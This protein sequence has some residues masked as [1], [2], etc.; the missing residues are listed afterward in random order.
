MA[1]FIVVYYQNINYLIG[2]YLNGG[3]MNCVNGCKYLADTLD[4]LEPE[5][6]P[7]ISAII[8]EYGYGEL[9]LL[10]FPG[11]TQELRL[12]CES[13]VAVR[14]HGQWI[15]RKDLKITIR[16]FLPVETNK[17]IKKRNTTIDQL[18]YCGVKLVINAFDE[19]RVLEIIPAPKTPGKIKSD[20]R[21]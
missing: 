10:K 16:D 13:L 2:I 20:T 6:L 5:M 9:I 14:R 8:K 15:L 1:W 4:L 3:N 11:G 12:G 19:K 7:V 21:L 18:C 17:M